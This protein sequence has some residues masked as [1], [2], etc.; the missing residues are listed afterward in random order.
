MTQVCN[1]KAER[2]LRNGIASIVVGISSIAAGN[3]CGY[4]LQA[5]TIYAQAKGEI[6]AIDVDTAIA[7]KVADAEASMSEL[8][9]LAFVDSDIYGIN[10]HW[11]LMKLA[12]LDS[13][14][15][16]VKDAESFSLQFEGLESRDGVLYAA[17][18]NSMLII[19]KA[20]GDTDYLCDGCTGYGLGAGERITDLAFADDGKLYTSVQFPGIPYTYLG[21]IRTDTGELS[22]IGNTGIE[23]I[24]AITVK[25]GVI[26]AMDNVGDFYT[27]DELSGFS[28]GVATG[29]LTGVTGMGTSPQAIDIPVTEEQDQQTEQPGSDSGEAAS[30]G[31]MGWLVMLLAGM[32]P[33]L[34]RHS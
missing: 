12:P 29:V 22:L 33:L 14:A 7:S 18:R 3:A 21:T 1:Y 30:A 10:Q 24:I 2:R 28:T 20:T 34:R 32:V 9:D 13:A 5:N 19:D 16:S 31:G 11:Q 26:Y 23:S 4:D 15:T 27:L 25:D 8:Q 6:Y 17:E